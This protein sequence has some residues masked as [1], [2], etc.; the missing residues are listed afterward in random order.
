MG[1]LTLHR[2]GVNGSV[3]VPKRARIENIARALIHCYGGKPDPSSGQEEALK[4][5]SRRLKGVE[6]IE[7]ENAP[8][9][10]ARINQNRIVLKSIL[11]HNVQNQLFDE[12]RTRQIVESASKIVRPFT[13]I[14]IE[15]FGEEIP[16]L[17]SAKAQ[18]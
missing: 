12:T 1:Q 14:I 11:R 17:L 9:N 18:T 10:V 2:E 6:K 7:F 13:R 8:H 15:H 3:A 4:L 16:E 5:L